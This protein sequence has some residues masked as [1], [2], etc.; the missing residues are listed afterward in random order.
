MSD[1]LR[2]RGNLLIGVLAAVLLMPSTASAWSDKYKP[3]AFHLGLSG[4]WIYS[5]GSGGFG[6]SIE[7]KLHLYDHIAVSVRFDGIIT[8]LVNETVLTPDEPGDIGIKQDVGTL[9]TALLKGDFY[10]TTTEVRPFGALGFGYVGGIRMGQYGSVGGI[11]QSLETY[12]GLGLVPQLGIQLRDFRLAVSYYAIFGA[13]AGSVGYS[14][15]A[16][17]IHGEFS[18]GDVEPGSL[19]YLLFELGYRFGGGKRT[20]PPEPL[21]TGPKETTEGGT[22]DE[23]QSPPGDEAG[24][25]P[26]EPDDDD[27]SGP[28]PTRQKTFF[29]P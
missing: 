3:F 5:S 17:D 22:P 26:V 10:L 28:N 25:E 29:D 6:A 21:D 13:G 14:L 9:Y 8:I 4:V 20:P 12:S 27:D 7:P 2:V 11:A 1:S 24:T 18:G 15:R 16:D 23:T 19:N